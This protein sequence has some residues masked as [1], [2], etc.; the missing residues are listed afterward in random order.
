LI[1]IPPLPAAA[2]NGHN[3]LRPPGLDRQS[4]VKFGRIIPIGTGLEN[5]GNFSGGKVL[6][7]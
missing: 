5:L 7:I 2:G 4:G 6:L 1:F 3:P